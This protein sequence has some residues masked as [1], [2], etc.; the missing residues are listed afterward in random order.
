MKSKNRIL[1]Y[2]LAGLA[3][4]FYQN[5]YFFASEEHIP[6]VLESNISE[7]L[8]VK[9][10]VKMVPSPNDKYSLFMMTDGY[11][12]PPEP[13]YI[14]D[15][16]VTIGKYAGYTVLYAILDG[17]AGEPAN[18]VF[19]TKDYKK[20]IMGRVFDVPGYPSTSDWYNSKDNISFNKE[21]I[22]AVDTFP[23][24]HPQEIQIGEYVLTR[25]NLWGEKINENYS[26]LLSKLPDLKYFY[27]KDTHTSYSGDKISPEYEFIDGSTRVIVQ[28]KNKV[29]FSYKLKVNFAKTDIES[30]ENTYNSYDT[31]FSQGCG[32]LGYSYVLKNITDNDLQKIGS[33]KSGIYLFTLKDDK[34]ILYKAQFDIKKEGDDNGFNAVDRLPSFAAYVDKNPILIFK[35]PWNRYVGLGEAIYSPMGGCGKPVI[36]LYPTEPTKVTIKFAEPIRFNINIPTYMD[37]WYVLAHP[38][39]SLTD[40]QPNET[41]CSVI[42]SRRFGSEYAKE[43]CAKGVYPYIYWS[44]AVSGEYPHNK[45]GWVVARADLDSFIHVKLGEIGLTDTER[46]DMASYWIPQM[47]K[48]NVPYYRVA[49]FQTQEMNKFIPMY[50]S[51][52]PDTTLR[53]FLDWTPLENKPTIQ[54]QPQT[55]KKIERKGFTLVEWGGLKQ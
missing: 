21:R 46:S 6:Q 44:G 45:E 35:D 27:R 51:P 12:A 34:N 8:P 16:V 1:I 11:G 24:S 31:I 41:D 32:R 5:W 10:V 23:V 15:E 25:E 39:G 17:D 3:I 22:I 53:V 19:V 50:V 37:G 43:A 26:E 49:F 28:N 9:P 30:P 36:Y 40:I 55:L 20:F 7:P 54:I 52:R 2:I 47:L 14:E 38:N 48:K 42:D 13:K 33:T 4:F 29:N 18:Y